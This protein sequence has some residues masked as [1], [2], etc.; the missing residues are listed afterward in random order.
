MELSEIL[1]KYFGYKNF[2]PLQEDII[3]SVLQGKDTFVLMPTGGGK[4][5]CY[6]LPALVLPGITL[7]ISPL[8]S[9]M[10][11]QVDS[12]LANGIAAGCMN[13]SMTSEEIRE[14]VR[15]A[16]TGQLKILYLAPERATLPG[17][18]ELLDKLSLSLVA[19]D[20][21][22]CISEWGHDFRPEY[23]QVHIFKEK[24]PNVPMI[25]LTAT[26]IEEVRQDIV[27]YLGMQSPLRFQSSFDRKNLEYRIAP[28]QNTYSQI[29]QYLSQHRQDSGIIY[30]MS[31]K[32][33]ESLAEKLRQDGFRTLA[34]HAGME[35][36]ERNETQERFIKDDV[37][38]IVATIAFGMGIDKPNVRYVLHYDLPKNIESYYQETGRAGRDGL[39]SECILFFS[40]ADKA[41]I[42]Y[43]IEQKESPE[44]KQIAAQKL[45][46]IIEFCQSSLCRRKFILRYFGENYPSPNCGRCDNCL[47]PPDKV[48]G[49]IAAQKFLST[50]FRLQR[51]FGI[52]YIIDI[53][54]GSQSQKIKDNQHDRLSTYGIGKEYTRNQWISMAYQMLEQGYIQK[55]TGQY[56]VISLTPLSRSVLFQKKEVS[57][58]LPA[59]KKEERRKEEYRKEDKKTLDSYNQEL[60]EELR[61]LRKSIADTLSVPPYIVFNDVSLKEMATFYPQ[62]E[63]EFLEIN[64][65]GK[66]KLLSFGQ[67]FM[68]AIYYF[69]KKNNI[70]LQIKSLSEK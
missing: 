19:I 18:L 39:P 69:C 2:L 13:S 36:Q 67:D 5:L 57:F 12:L 15:R 6:Q 23:R 14:V 52:N 40:Y 37:E 59:P 38:I 1:N 11:D 21:A 65:V 3:K 49:T 8:I 4:S 68:E 30:C 55:D 58:V 35:A 50:V 60:F 44:E 53:L 56:P 7:V 22:H 51:S 61:K 41:K 17:F 42:E 26:A 62:S 33:T 63:E 28:K 32:S 64:G 9:L 27:K 45:R 10:K 20:E 43:F 48:M 47:N 25:A 46:Y 29:M 66:K 54:L 70:P 31:R 34:Y 24:Y 16:R